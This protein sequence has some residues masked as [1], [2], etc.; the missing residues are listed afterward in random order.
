MRKRRA[1]C[2]DFSSPDTSFRGQSFRGQG[3][4]FRKTRAAATAR[5]LTLCTSPTSRMR[6]EAQPRSRA[7]VHGGRER[8]MQS[9]MMQLL[10]RR[11]LFDAVLADGILTVTGTSA[12]DRISVVYAHIAPDFRV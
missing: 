9:R 2:V 7:R 12:N 4:T 6:A 8:S 10:E 1:T 11:I 3:Q 5:N